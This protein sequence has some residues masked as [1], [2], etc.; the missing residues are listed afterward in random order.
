M[1]VLVIGRSG[2]LATSLLSAAKPQGIQLL[3]ASRPQLDITSPASVRNTLE[4]VRPALV[5][6]A[7]AYTAVD[8]A[9]E[10]R[11][12]AFAV[13]AEGPAHLASECRR[14]DIPLIHVSTDYVFDGRKQAP[15]TEDDA[16][17]PLNVYGQSKLA[18]EEAVRQ[19][20]AKH[21]ILRTSWV[22][23]PFGHN[24]ARTMLRL[25]QA[26]GTLNIVADQHGSPTYAPHLAGAILRLVSKLQSGQDS[27]PWGI[28][29]LCGSGETTWHGFAR[30]IFSCSARLGG[31]TAEVQAISTAEYPTPARRPANSRLSCAKLEQ[32]FGIRLPRWQEGVAL[33]VE[34]IL[35]RRKKA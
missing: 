6:N 27:L 34:K 29:H 14:L 33:C 5:I 13:N 28:F 15:Y 17:A 9:E 23:S 19:V 4:D 16:P 12:M 10:E 25:A 30:E 1:K 2:Q 8:K 22:F 20:W 31:P 21:I 26:H 24:F 3:A 11:D 32:S 18:G 35:E 7:A